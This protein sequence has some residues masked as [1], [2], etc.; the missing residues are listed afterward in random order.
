MG[1]KNA[2]QEDMTI[3]KS[4]EIEE[5]KILNKDILVFQNRKDDYPHEKKA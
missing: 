2:W 5:G 4:I 3:R 1:G